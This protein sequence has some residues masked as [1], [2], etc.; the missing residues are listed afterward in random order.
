VSTRVLLAM[1]AS[2]LLHASWNAWV[3]SRPD[4]Y[5]ALIALGVGAAWPNLILLAFGG[6]P[7][8]AA[9]GWIAATILLSVPAQALLGS[10]YREADLAVAYPI[11]RGLNPLVI[12]IAA[13]PVFG[14]RLGR[15]NLAG[16]LCISAGIAGIGWEAARRSRTITLRGL[17]FAALAALVTA[18]GALTDS[19]GA[20]VSNDPLSYAPIIAIGNGAAM[21]AY[22]ARR[23]NVGAVLAQHWQIALFA[24][25]LSTGSYLLAIWS[26]TQAPVALVVSLR[27]TSMLFAVA[28]GALLLRER[29][30]PWRWLAVALVFAGVLLIRG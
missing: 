23:T 27:E 2:A 20:R 18:A 14:E 7:T 11:V 13:I 25:L 19:M 6:L 26:L 8:H 29:V 24:P 16:V 12:A 28:I 17:G 9:W 5:G 10:A 15:G 21:A 1:L 30:G 4:P 3:K 22:Q